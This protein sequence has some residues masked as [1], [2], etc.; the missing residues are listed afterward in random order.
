MAQNYTRQ[1]TLSDGDTITASL[2]ND[3]YNQLVNAFTYSSTSASSTGHR[4]DGS[5]GQGGNIFKIGDLD[6]LN[7]IEVDSTNN[8]WGFYVEVSSAA[9]EQIRIQDGSI[10]PVTTNDIDLGT[11]SLQFKDLYIDGTAN[12]DSLTLTSGAT[13]TT[14]LDEDDLSSDSATALVTQQSVKAYIDAQV[15]AQDFDFQADSGGALSIDL[16]S[17]TMTFTGGTGI[18]TTGLANDVTFAI[19]S[20]VTTLTG[21]QT[22]TNK[23]LTTPVIS[24]ISNTGT[25]TLPTSTD[26]LVGRATTDTLTNKTL[27]SPDVN[28]PDIDGGT[29]D[30][31]TI[32][33]SDITVGTGKTLDVSGGT[34]TLADNQISG[35]KVEGGTIASTTITSLASTTVDTTNLEVTNIKAKDGTSAGSIADSTGVVTLASSV[36]TTT[37]INGGTIDGATIGG[38]TTAAGSF[39]SVNATSL[40]VA[41]TVEFDGLSGTGSVTVTDILD[42]DNMSSN[43]ATALATQQSI[44]AYVDSQVATADTLAEVLGNGNTTG[45]TDIQFSAGDNITNASGD[46]TIDIAGDLILDADGGDIRFLDGGTEFGR[47]FGSSNNFYIQ[48]RQTDKDMI[49]QGIDGGS[50]ITALSLDMSSAGA[51]TFNG[52]LTVNGADVTVTANIK[53]AGDSDTY[54]G[55]HGNDLWR[56]VTGGTERFEVS[57]SGIIINDLSADADFRVESNGNTHALFVDAGNDRVDMAVPLRV[58]YNEIT[59][60]G[61][62][63]IGQF[64]TAKSGTGELWTDINTGANGYSSMPSEISVMNTADDTTNTFAGI[65]FQAG[66]TSAGS[67]VSAAR[68]GAIRTAAL[69]A[70][71]AFATRA[72]TTGTMAEHMRLTNDGKFGIGLNAPAKPL[73]VSA[74]GTAVGAV[75]YDV[76]I[77]QNSDA[78]GIRLVDAG[79]GG[80]NGGH[81]GLG[82]DNGN[83]RVASAGKLSFATGLSTSDS[84]FNGGTERV[85]FDSNG[86]IYFFDNGG[87][88]FYYDAS[89]GLTINEAGDDRD[90]RVESNNSAYAVYVDAAQDSVGILTNATD[91][92]LNVNSQS[93]SKDAIRIV[94]SGGNNF[95]AGYGNQGNL[96]FTI[97]ELGADDPAILTLYRNGIASHI[98]DPDANSET[99]FNEQGEN[100]DFRVESDNNANMLVVDAGNDR[101]GVGGT[102]TAPLDVRGANSATF[103]RGQLYIS[104][105]ESAAI[106]QG[107]QISLGGTYSGTSD[108]FFAS[109]AGRKENDTAGNYDGYLSLATRANGGNNTE[110]MRITS[111]GFVGINETSPDYHLHV[112]SGT[113][114]VVAKFESTDSTSVIQFVDSGGNS[115]FGTT[116]STARISPNGSYA[117][118]E[119]SQSAVVLN[120]ASQDTDFRV[121]SDTNANAIFMNAGQGITYF[122]HG[123]TMTGNTFNFQA[124]VL[125]GFS[126]GSSNAVYSVLSQGGQDGDLYLVSNAYPANLGSSRNVIIQGG[127]SGGSSP[128]ETARFNPEDGVIFNEQSIAAHDFRV[129]SNSNSHMLFVNAGLD[130][131]AI[132]SGSISAPSGYHLFSYGSGSG[133]RSAFVH[134]AGDGGIVVSGAAGGSAAS[135]IFGNNWGTNGATFSEEYRIFMDGADDGLKFNYNANTATALTLKSTGTVVVNDGGAN[136]D[137]RVE[138]QNEAN[139]LFVDADSDVVGIKNSSPADG[140]T[141][142]SIGGD[143]ITTKKPTVNINDTTNGASLTLRGGSPTIY[144]DATSGGTPTLVTDG[145]QLRIDDGT[146]D[147]NSDAIAIIG[148]DGGTTVFNESA[149]NIDFRVESDSNANALIVDA[150]LSHVGINRA[151]NSVVGLTVNSTQTNSSYYAFEASNSSNQ[152]RFIVRSDGQSDFF[153]GNNANTLRIG[154]AGAETVFNDASTDRDFRVE[155]DSN[156][157]A[158]FVDAGTSRV[159]IGRSNPQAKLDVNAGTTKGIEIALGTSGVPFINFLYGASTVGS[160]TTNGSTTTYNTSSDQRLKENIVD[161]PSASDDIDAI[162]VRSFDW[163]SDGL[164]LIHISEPTR[165]Y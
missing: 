47:V 146:L 2:F 49:F 94:G 115:E 143:V 97:A 4:H 16:D 75:D 140:A 61:N 127:T 84:L 43:S 80:G 132:G 135:V 155:S 99:V 156:T 129:E 70:D 157:H 131:V 137:F 160:I 52:N 44:K 87:A 30:G 142:L 130:Q 23:T 165:P 151:A 141:R 66:E 118:L 163:K 106:N 117:V 88:S 60:T 24:T 9:V 78:A 112:K 124:N 164:S 83:L 136:S 85:R 29:I 71:L 37:D 108:T 50:T 12:V 20:T 150:G 125:N 113:T 89:A 38:T 100:V 39:T 116:G 56:V 119:A 154:I 36:L 32:A 55:F 31:A 103:G 72:A 53:H 1:S 54:Y 79:D 121:E 33:T 58:G 123:N 6:F 48:A 19:D 109:I 5:A 18:T 73:H 15:T 62:S 14:I 161:A 69:S 34:L 145:Q 91:A 40:D 10:V 86:D 158:L 138:S 95:I 90:F 11:S 42:Q 120:N 92:A 111:G 98:L 21:T 104:N 59:A 148:I 105:T 134:G 74:G 7:K 63:G 153:D 144:F 82:N 3:E 22:L 139:M 162:Q 13:V 67:G 25:L 114:N 57:N 101:V 128:K 159:G 46:F 35:D 77:F 93:G 27:T 147:A 110:H 28:T 107:S 149:Q 8:R 45:G 81:S 17:E 65:F 76:A 133:A 41:G 126:I 122:G 102:P 96:A 68:I 64:A 26:T 152:T 51:A